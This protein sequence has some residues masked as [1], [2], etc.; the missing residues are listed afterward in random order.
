MF[1]MNF[2]KILIIINPA[3]GHEEPILSYLNTVFKD[4]EIDWEVSVTKAEGDS[5]SIARE[6]VGKVDV[7]AVYGGD[8]S[9]A[10]V[11]KVLYGSDTPLAIIPGGTANVMSKELGIPQNSLA[12]I[13][14]LKGDTAKILHMDI[15]SANDELFFIRVNVGIMAD[16]VL[17][18]SREMK[19]KV[20]RLAYGIAAIQTLIKSDVDQYQL[21]I[22]GE[23]I[24]KEGVALTVT[25]CGNIGIGDYSFLPDIS[26]R[27]GFLD[28][29]LLHEANLM[30]VLRVAGATFFKTDSEILEHWKCK[31]VKIEFDKTH[32]FVLDD[33][34]RHADSIYIKVIPGALKVVVPKD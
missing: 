4:S 1:D 30:S 33:C 34:E 18:A 13:E 6:Y 8:G 23:K 21:T 15:A 12:A 25:N 10:E 9:I 20:G 24:S 17:E 22:D 32:R 19:D 16:M 29:I 31:E 26:I 3:S 2:K 27:D 7:I 11:A 14:L 5:T 28:V